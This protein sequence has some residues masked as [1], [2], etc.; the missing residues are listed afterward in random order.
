MKEAHREKASRQK[1]TTNLL[2]RLTPSEK[3]NVRQHASDAGLTVSEY[4]RR[5]ITGRRIVSAAD[6]KM[7]NELRRIAGLM[8]HIHNESGGAY[9]DLTAKAIGE[10]TNAIKR[11]GNHRELK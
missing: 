6:N 9:R 8:K 3:G 4:L 10:V 5:R 1:K 7:I 2:I 11:I